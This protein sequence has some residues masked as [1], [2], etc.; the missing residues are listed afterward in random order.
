MSKLPDSKLRA[1]IGIYEDL[2]E[3]FGELADIFIGNVTMDETT[4]AGEYQPFL[5]LLAEFHFNPENERLYKDVI[6]KIN[7]IEEK[8]LKLRGQIDSNFTKGKFIS[9]KR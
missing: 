9:R 5:K 6:S 3:D 4:E 7:F 2:M 8:L 1:E